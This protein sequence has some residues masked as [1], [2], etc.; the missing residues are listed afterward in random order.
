MSSKNNDVNVITHPGSTAEDMLDY[1]K[2][3]ARRKPDILMTHAST[4]D[5]INGVNLMKKVRKLVKVV[6]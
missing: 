3:I 4:N 6:L 5:I 1:F 2:P